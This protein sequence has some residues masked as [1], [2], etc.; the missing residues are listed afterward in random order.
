MQLALPPH[1]DGRLHYARI[2]HIFTVRID[3]SRDRVFVSIVP[4]E[5]TMIADPITAYP[6]LRLKATTKANCEIFGLSMIHPDEPYI[7]P[8]DGVDVGGS[9]QASTS[10]YWRCP[11]SIKTM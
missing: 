7:I 11:F 1:P 9:L 5:D 6:I 3:R 10:L 8:T 4:F 2:M